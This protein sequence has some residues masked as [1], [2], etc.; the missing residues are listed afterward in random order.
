M[1]ENE[2]VSIDKKMVILITHGMGDQSNKP[3][4][5][6]K[7]AT[8]FEKSYTKMQKKFD[9]SFKKIA[10]KE[11]RDENYYLNKLHIAPVLWAEVLQEKQNTLKKRITKCRYGVNCENKNLKY[12]TIWR[13]L[14]KFLIDFLS[15]AIA[16]YKSI[17]S[18]LTYDKIQAKFLETLQ[19][20]VREE[21]GVEKDSPLCIIA[22]MCPHLSG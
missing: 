13:G 17:T 22:E 15:D 18:R 16:Y 14:R 2:N 7:Y 20:L 5:S 10:R 8:K 3:K 4:C 19:K 11:N 9:K 21:D 12:R 1:T 6:K